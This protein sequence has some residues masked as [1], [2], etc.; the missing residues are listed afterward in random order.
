MVLGAVMLLSLV[1]LSINTM[2]VGKTTTMLEAEA[3]LTAISLAQS[4]ID[5]IQRKSYD[6][7]TVS[8]LVYDPSNFTAAGSLGCSSTEAAN[9]PLPD[10]TVPYKSDTYYNDVDDYNNYRRTAFTSLLGNFTIVDSV[11]YVSESDPNLRSST[12]TFFKKIVV[13]VTHPNMSY[14]MT[15]SDIAV[16]RRY[17]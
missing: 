4:M 11:Y 1:S 8:A 9:V 12:Q 3:N 2:I 15:I 14:P 17:F 6:A 16:Y 13:K 10:A 7:V 5:E